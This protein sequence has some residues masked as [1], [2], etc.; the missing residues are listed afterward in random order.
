MNLYQ[1]SFDRNRSDNS[2]DGNFSDGGGDDDDDDDDD[3]NNDDDE[4]MSM[5]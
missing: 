4:V 3:N 5:I 1:C 2:G